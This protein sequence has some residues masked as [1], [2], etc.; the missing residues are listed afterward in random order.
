MED[1]GDAAPSSMAAN[2]QYTRIDAGWADSNYSKQFEARNLNPEARSWTDLVALGI[3]RAADYGIARV[4]LQN[5]A[6]GRQ[7]TAYGNNGLG[8]AGTVQVGTNLN[9]TSLLF[10]GVLAFVA[11]RAFK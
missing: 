1:Y 4:S 9:L 6:P 7:M 2:A 5:S 8:Q 11:V 3:S 10:W